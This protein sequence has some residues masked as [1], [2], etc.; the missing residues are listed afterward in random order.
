MFTHQIDRPPQGGG[1]PHKPARALHSFP[2]T[3]LDVALPTPLRLTGAAGPSYVPTE[4]D[5]GRCGVPHTMGCSCHGCLDPKREKLSSTWTLVIRCFILI[6]YLPSECDLIPRLI[7]DC[8]SG[9][10]AWHC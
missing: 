10:Q 6:L 8:I 2:G 5:P 9:G 1:M 3:A 7:I 4:A